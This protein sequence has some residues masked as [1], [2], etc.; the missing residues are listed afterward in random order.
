[1]HRVIIVALEPRRLWRRVAQYLNVTAGQ[2]F[3]VRLKSSIRL[4]TLPW[5]HDARV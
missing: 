2:A 3:P 5:A 1:M 4:G